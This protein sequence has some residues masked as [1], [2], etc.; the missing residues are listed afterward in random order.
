MEKNITEIWK[1]IPGYSGYYEASTLGRIRSIERDVVSYSRNGTRYVKRLKSVVLSQA[2]TNKNGYLVKT[3]LL[4]SNGKHKMFVVAR[5]IALTFIPN[6]DNLPQV[7]H[8]D[9]DP[10][11]N[12]W[13]NLEWCDATYNNRYG[14]RSIRESIT[15]SRPIL[16]FLLDGTFIKRWNSSKEVEKTLGYYHKGICLCCEGVYKQSKGFIWRYE[17]EQV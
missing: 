13:T 9:E 2:T 8:K 14:T 7:N 4:S 12:V 6:P 16:Q 1:V 11:N 15:K 3:V 10:T 5:L 17:E